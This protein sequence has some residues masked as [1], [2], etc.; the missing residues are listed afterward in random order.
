MRLDAVPYLVER[1]GTQQREPAG[2]PRRPEAACA[3]SSTRAIR[4]PHAA[5][6]GQPVAG[7]RAALFRRRRRMPHGVPLPADAAHLH[8]DRAARTAIPITDIMRQT[9]DIPANCQWAIFLR[10]HDELTLEMVTDRER[11]YLWKHYAA[12]QRMRLNLGIRRRLAPLMENDR[13]RIELMNGLLLSMP[14]TPVIYYG[15]EIGMGDNIYPRRP[16]RRAHAD[17]VV[18]RPQ[19]RLLARRSGAALSAAD[20][21]CRSTAIRRSTSRRRPR[22]PSSLLNWMKRLIAVRKARRAFGRG[23]LRFL[24]PANR[25]VLAY[26]A[27]STRTRPCCASSTCRA[28]RRRWSSILPASPAAS[29][30]ELVRPQRLSADRRAALSADAAGLRLLLVPARATRARPSRHGAR[31][32][33]AGVRHPGAARAAGASLLDQPQP[34]Q[35]RERG[36]CRP[37]CRRG[38]GSP[39]KDAQDRRASPRSSP[40]PSSTALA[41]D[42]RRGRAAARAQAALLAAARAR[43][44]RSRTAMPRALLPCTAGARAPRP[45]RGRDLRRAGRAANS[46]WRWSQAMRGGASIPAGEAARIVFRSTPALSPSA[47]LPEEPVVKRIGGEQ[48][49]SSVVDRGLRASSSSIA[50]SSAGIH[51][52]IEMARFLTESPRFANT[53]P[54]LGALH[55]VARRRRDDGA[56]A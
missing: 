30:V 27:R 12:D 22:S 34:P 16:R 32:P 54:L 36:R 13:R 50:A 46:R 45:A 10:N 37:I 7:G 31:R 41:A 29:P 47:T 51:P 55:L 4:R 44:G 28:R 19:R 40:R 52:E 15:D 6:R 9:P 25:K 14:G 17:A 2:D 23:D 8:G 1:E 21:G 39:A 26:P 18:A 43:P 53:P 24:Y 48:S 35:L 49:N 20:H 11:D 3:P 38:A 5:R 56:R 42:R 33:A